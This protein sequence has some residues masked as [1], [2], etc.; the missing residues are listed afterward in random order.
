MLSQEYWKLFL[1]TGLPE[2]YLMYNSARKMEKDHV[3]DNSGT[4]AAG[5][6][7]Q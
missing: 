1:E 4:G 2:V 3:F 5:H 6:T 7:L